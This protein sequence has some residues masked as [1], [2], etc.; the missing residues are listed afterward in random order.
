MALKEEN[1]GIE[2]IC[3]ALFIV[4]KMGNLLKWSWVGNC[5]CIQT[6]VDNMIQ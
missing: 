5:G 1:V 2:K 3:I 4:I 6:N